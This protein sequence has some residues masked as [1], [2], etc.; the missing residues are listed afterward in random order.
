MIQDDFNL[1]KYD[2]TFPQELIAQEPATKRDNSKLLVIDRKTSS[3]SKKRFSEITNLFKPGDLLVLN[4]TK[5][6]KARLKAKRSSGGKVEVFLLKEIQPGVW[7]VLLKPGKR[8]KINERIFFED[9]PITATINETNQQGSWSITF[10]QKNIEPL[11]SS[12]GQVP[13]PPYIKKPLTAETQYQ[14][15]YAENQGAVAAP[16]AGFHFTPKLLNDLKKIGVEIV[17]ITLHCGLGTFRPVK[18]TDIRKHSMH[19]EWVSLSAEAAE[20]INAAKLSKRRVIAVGT[21]SIRTLESVA[22]KSK[23]HDKLLSPFSGE[24]DFYIYPGY[25]FKVIDAVI[26]NFHTPCSTNLILISTFAGIDLI[27]QSYDYA[28]ENRFRF[29][30][31]GD[32]MFII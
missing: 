23:N 30:S 24:T 32:S 29:F 7:Q 20:K 26:T 2:F 15:V 1:S 16:T 22:D 27:K 28:I 5:V 9:S 4:D 31:F 3:F 18:S 17:F 12:L 8:I 14:T 19:S 13:L 10:S 25:S 11:I 6:I 21:T